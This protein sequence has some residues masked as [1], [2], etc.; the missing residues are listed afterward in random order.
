LADCRLSG[1]NTAWRVPTR[2][3]VDSTD[4]TGERNA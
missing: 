4:K 1:G 3:A 2:S